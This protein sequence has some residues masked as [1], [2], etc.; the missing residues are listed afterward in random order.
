MKTM[1]IIPARYDSV[2]LPGKVLID[3]NGKPMIQ[4][5]YERVSRYEDL[6]FVIVATDDQRI[7]DVVKSF[8]G[9]VIMTSVHHKNGT[10]RIAEVANLF[11]EY[12]IVVNVQ[13]DEPMIT[14]DA[15]RILYE[16][17]QDDSDVQMATLKVIMDE[18]D[19]DN[20]AAVKVLT[21]VN[22]NALY[23]GRSINPYPRNRDTEYVAYKHIGIYAYTREFLLKYS[24]L[25]KLKL[26]SIENLEQ[27]RVLENGYNI[28]V[29]PCDYNGISVD[30]IEDLE[31]VKSY[32]A[33]NYSVMG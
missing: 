20:P 14:S 31:K 1:C 33:N 16:C 5:V 29:L 19:Y 6:D 8:N 22:N 30:T 25:P 10:E 3:I 4:R 13:G 18:N 12:E 28:R 17:M 27:L 7:Y 15:I 2:R 32:F 24:L 11:P 9:N 23:F 26:E 21:D